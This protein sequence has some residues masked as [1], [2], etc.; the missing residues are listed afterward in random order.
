MPP[1]S[2]DAATDEKPTGGKLWRG[3]A[4]ETLRDGEHLGPWLIARDTH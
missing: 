1:H 4:H 3:Y 2:E